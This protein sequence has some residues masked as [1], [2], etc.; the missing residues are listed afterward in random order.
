MVHIYG[1]S[2]ASPW[3]R[4]TPW[5]SGGVTS[6]SW[7]LGLQHWLLTGVPTASYALHCVGGRSPQP[8]SQASRAGLMSWSTFSKTS[9]RHQRYFFL[10]LYLSCPY[11]PVCL[12]YYALYAS[13]FRSHCI[14]QGL[15]IPHLL[16]SLRIFSSG[17]PASERQVSLL[18]LWDQWSLPSLLTLYSENWS[19]ASPGYLRECSGGK[20]MTCHT[21]LQKKLFLILSYRNPLYTCK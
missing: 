14:F 3:V 11:F 12:F 1:G 9:V 2:W 17:S 10:S 15:F 4:L 13:Y 6:W 20:R 21:G 8:A 7:T 18:L 19:L 5:W 16:W